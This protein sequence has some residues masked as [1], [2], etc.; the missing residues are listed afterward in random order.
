MG[1]LVGVV[2]GFLFLF[3]CCFVAF[4]RG[5]CG[6]AS[7]RQ[8]KT[9][10]SVW[11]DH[12]YGDGSDSSRSSR[13]AG[14][15]PG[16][17]VDAHGGDDSIPTHVDR[18]ASGRGLGSFIDRMSTTFSGRGAEAG[19]GQGQGSGGPPRVSVFGTVNPLVSGG[20]SK[21]GKQRDE[22]GSDRGRV[23]SGALP[24][25]RSGSVLS[26][27]ISYAG[28]SARLAPAQHQA[29]QQGADL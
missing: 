4:R 29:E 15:G 1:V 27:H 7:S 11:S 10:Y 5:L 14:Q 2:L 9:A 19:E 28:R 12:Y 8:K 3:C 6:K 18:V 13:R 16:A 21:S 25:H 26:T 17:S 22:S 20:S 23:G 24:P